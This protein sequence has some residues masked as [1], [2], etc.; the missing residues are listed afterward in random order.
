M[1]AVTDKGRRSLRLRGYDYSQ[2]GMYFITICTYGR[3]LLFGEVVEV[4]MVVNQMGKVVEEEWLRTPALRPYVT[5]DEFVVMPN[6]VHGIIVF[7][8][9]GIRSVGAHSCAPLQQARLQRQPRSLGSLIAGFKSAT[10]KRI[11][12]L[13]GSP[14]VLLWQRNYHEYV[15]RNEKDLSRIRDYIL[16]NPLRWELDRENPARRGEDEFDRWLASLSQRDRKGHREDI[17]CRG[18]S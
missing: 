8:D 15:I 3:E 6:H 7:S 12:N 1:T 14:G 13:R 9:A 17:S 4:E 18:N 16:T 11:N 2:V 10:T 5:L